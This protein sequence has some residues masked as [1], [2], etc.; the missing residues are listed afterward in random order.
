MR[1][2]WLLAVLL[3]STTCGVSRRDQGDPSRVSA[4][5]SSGPI[6]AGSTW[7]WF[8]GSGVI[9]EGDEARFVEGSI[10]EDLVRQ[11]T[12]RGFVG[13]SSESADYLV[14]FVVAPTEEL[15]PEEVSRRFG[16]SLGGESWRREPTGSLLVLVYDQRARRVVWKAVVQAGV[17]RNLD[18]AR[19][20][21]RLVEHVERVFR[22]FPS[23]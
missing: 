20:R 7:A 17:Q 21:E 5:S 3:V 13:A 18:P 14:G 16:L 9:G 2:V 4:V 22:T 6:A 15:D 1:P 8:S 11:L 23:G 19:R 10:R 12:G